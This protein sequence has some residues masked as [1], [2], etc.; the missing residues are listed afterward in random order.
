MLTQNGELRPLG[1]FNWTLPAWV[2]KTSDGKAINVCPSAG[3]C[4]KF[5]YARN[6]TYNFPAVKAAHLRNLERVTSDLGGWTVDMMNELSARKFRQSRVPILPGYPR[7]HLT[8]R[9]AQLLDRGAKVVRIHD[10]GDFLS[11][12][13]LIAWLTIA[14]QTPDVLFYAYTKEVTRMRRVAAGSAPANFLWCY[15]MGGKEDHLLDLDVDRHADVFPD[16]AAIEA[17]GYE[18]QD[19]HDLLCVVSANHRVGI[20]ANNIP[21]FNKR[22]AGRTFAQVEVDLNRHRRASA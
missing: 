17:A 13:Y 3:A 9:V 19:D 16:E 5:C 10:S 11:D 15:S 2:A 12:E 21:H 22:L 1:I 14:E 4:V 7:G 18:N 20:P 8:P 6:G